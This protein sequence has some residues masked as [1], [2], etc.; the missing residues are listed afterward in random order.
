MKAL[1]LY[2][3]KAGHT[4]RYAEMIA[5]EIDAECISV[6]KAVQ[7]DFETYDLCVYGGS[8]HAAGIDGYK[9]F[10]ELV[11]MS[12]KETVIFAV[13]ASP[14]KDG[15]VEEIRRNS[16]ISTEEKGIP[17]FY[18]RG[19]FDYSRLPL[20]DKAL[21]FLLKMKLR[22]KKDKNPDDSALL[23]SY[24]KPLDTVKKENINEMVEYIKGNYE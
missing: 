7:V 1:V 11:R 19:G 21:M 22:M 4:K 18:L 15:I 5:K 24:E 3:T 16:F 6:E 20:F 14:K 17:L 8:L 12:S 13:G 10:R 2:K 23:A 9:Y